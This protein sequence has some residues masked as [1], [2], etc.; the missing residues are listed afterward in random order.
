MKELHTHMPAYPCVH[1][2]T[3]PSF[4]CVWV[5]RKQCKLYCMCACESVY[6]SRRQRKLGHRGCLSW[7]A[8]TWRGVG[9]FSMNKGKSKRRL[10]LLLLYQFIRISK[11][12]LSTPD[13]PKTLI[14]H[15]WQLNFTW[16]H[17]PALTFFSLYIYSV[18]IVT[19]VAIKGKIIHCFGLQSQHLGNVWPG[20]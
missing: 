19:P 3:K 11:M 9:W 12:M 17:H 5:S 20:I 8:A 2:I 13:F 16:E 1:A 18:V 4:F 15:P 7:Q 10:S 6:V 14:F